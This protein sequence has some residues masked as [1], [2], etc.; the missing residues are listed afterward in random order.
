LF[1]TFNA[2][3]DSKKQMVF[4]CDRPVSELKGFNDR[5]LSRLGQGLNVNLQPPKYE[6]RFAI[7]KNK[8]ETQNIDIPDE[9]LDLISKNVS[10]NI[11]DLEATLNKLTAYIKLVKKPVTLETAQQLLKDD[12]ASPKQANVSI[13]IIQRVVAEYYHLS[14]ND[15]KGKK[16]TQNIVYPRQ[17]AMSIIRELTE[18]STTEIGQFIGGRDQ[19]TVMHSCDKIEGLIH[20][21]PQV[22]SLIQTLIRLI[23]DYSAKS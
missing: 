9:V 2:L 20:S 22:D 6:T 4:T 5:L 7:L 18:N 13:E 19:T 11:R 15:L 14:P 12:F 8:T 16:K 1:Y 17:L 10:T 21:D 3:S 23:K